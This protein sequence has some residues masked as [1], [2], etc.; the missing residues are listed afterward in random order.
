VEECYV[1][2]FVT[3]KEAQALLG[4]SR[5]TVDAMLRDGRLTPYEL[6]ANR[7]RRYVKRDQVEDLKRI[8]PVERS[9]MRKTG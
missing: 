5:F 3:L 2:E 9:P 6:P 8:R 7:R 4:V 1:D